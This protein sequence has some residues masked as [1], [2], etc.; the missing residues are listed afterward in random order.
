M[1]IRET[2]ASLLEAKQISKSFGPNPALRDISFD[3]RPGEVHVLAGENGAGKSTL[4]DILSGI[5]TEFHGE[6]RVGGVVRRFRHPKDALRAGVAMVHQELSLIGSLS[7]SDNLFLGRERTGRFGLV[8]ARRQTHEARALLRELDLDDVSED[9]LLERLPMSTQQLVEI[10]RALA[11][12]A[13]VLLLDEPTSALREPE[14]LHLFDR[15]DALRRQGKG[16]V[17]VSHKM[18]EI[19]R[20]ADRITV[21]RDGMLVGT[22]AASELPANELVRWMVGRELSSGKRA[23]AVRRNVA[24]KVEHLHI[25]GGGLPKADGRLAVDDVSFE[26]RSGEILGLSGLR[27]SGA[28]DILHAIFGDRSGRAAGIV[29]LPGR[30]DDKG[31][32]RIDLARDETSPAV[33]IRRGIMLLTNDRKGKGL[34]LDMDSNEN[35]SL[36]S[37]PR[38]SSGGILRAGLETSAVTRAFLQLGLK[39]QIAAPVRLLSGGNQQKVVLAKCLLTE[40]QILLLDE[41]TRGVDVGA[42]TEIHALL[43]ECA[44]RGMAIVLVTSELPELLRLADRIL[45]LHRGRCTAEFT[46]SEAT[47]EK[48]VHA[49][50]GR[51]PLQGGPRCSTPGRRVVR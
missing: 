20:L 45:V 22:K 14:V 5:H 28:S 13:N 41:P 40:P 35:A 37:L 27:G 42:K 34:V 8:D 1:P 38:Y 23:N 26:L 36:A 7:V 3:V 50:F 51:G 2:V 30:H 18:D 32:A 19:Y 49:A 9:E 29:C 33:A 15:I 17:Y 43:A 16:I 21:L 11:A 44:G 48:I 25:G 46:R 10:A 47:H 39:G 4:L 12:K 24:L 6:I 31:E